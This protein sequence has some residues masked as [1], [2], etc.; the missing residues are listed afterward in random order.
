MSTQD[1]ISIKDKTFKNRFTLKPMALR[2]ALAPVC[3][4]ISKL[5]LVTTASYDLF[6]QLATKNP[7][8]RMNNYFLEEH[9]TA[10]HPTYT[11]L[12]SRLSSA[13]D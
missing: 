3:N 6:Y 12:A 7:W 13:V 10:P 8:E 5:N 11:E 4:P 2:C 1:K 9:I